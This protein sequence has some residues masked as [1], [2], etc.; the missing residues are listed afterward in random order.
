MKCGGKKNGARKKSPGL[1]VS[2]LF[3]IEYLT[4]TGSLS[5]DAAEVGG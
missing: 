4:V 5:R 1:Y 3:K 2:Y